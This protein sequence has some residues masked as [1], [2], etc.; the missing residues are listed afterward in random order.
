MTVG[1]P[2][3][4]Q[5][6][7]DL[8]V[9]VVSTGFGRAPFSLRLLANG[10]AIETR[11]IVPPADGTPVDET[12]TVL[13]DAAT[14]TVFTAEIPVDESE[15]VVENNTRSA[16]VSPA[17]RKRRVLMLEGAPGFEHSF[18]GRALAGD[19][20][21]EVDVVTRKGKNGDGQDTFFVQA[22]GDRGTSLTT[23]FPSKREALYQYDAIIVANVDGDFFT[24]AQLAM[25]ADFVS[26][27]GGGLLVLGGR[28]F[29]QRGLSG[30]PLE[31]VLPV[32]LNDRKGGVAR[33]GGQDPS[34]QHKVALT[35]DGET[36]PIMR[37]GPIDQTRRVWSG[38]PALASSA[39]LGAARPGAT[40]LALTAVTSGAVTPIVVVQRYG[41][42]RSMVFAGEASW[43][44]KMMAASTDRTYE[45]FWRQAARWLAVDAPDPVSI[46]VPDAAEAGDA[47]GISV[48]ARDT[49]HAPAADA[50]VDATLVAPWGDTTALKLR[51]ADATSGR[52]MATATPDRAGLYRVR[53]EA[54]RGGPSLGASDRWMLVG[55]ADREFA[56]PRL[57]EAWLRRVARTSGGQYVR[58]ENASSIVNGL[59]SAVPQD[60]A[61]E[62]R[63]LWH[64][65]WAFAL[66][67]ALLSAEWILRRAWGLR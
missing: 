29:S 45:T 10:R 32:E 35:L 14:P 2:R 39:P 28:S 6:S 5:A 64:E 62:Q 63:D 17:G 48:D 67:V 36:H 15:L 11:R 50:T 57:N 52:W 8:H 33:A 51:R 12:F 3:L 34:G 66:V 54:K 20:T 18:L 1:D 46:T 23:G 58:A 31:D 38:L 44:W 37:M 60:V 13:P 61:P 27:R 7:V 25:A 9:T 43:R 19:P 26:E 4:D 30:T 42:G 16:F 53:A 49:L 21:L 59:V 41:R 55:G 22:G 40:V 65:P 47:L 24:R 56:D